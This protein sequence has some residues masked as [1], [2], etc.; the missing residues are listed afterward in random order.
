MDKAMV[1]RG[2]GAIV[3]AIIAALLLGWLLKDKSDQRQEVVDM[4]IPSLMGSNTTDETTPSLLNESKSLISNTVDSVKDTGTAVIASASSVTSSATEKVTDATSA[5]LN[6]ANDAVNGAVQNTSSMKPG[7][8][9]RPS[10]ANEEKEIVDNTR[11][12]I[13]KG[14]ADHQKNNQQMTQNDSSTSA[15]DT[16]V[17]STNSTTA[18]KAI[19][20]AFKPQIVKKKKK[21]KKKAVPQPKKVAKA[22]TATNIPT[23]ASG[24]YSIQLLATSSQ[25]RANKLAKTMKSE[26]YQ[27]FVTETTRN[28]KV[29]FRVRVGG[30]SNRGSAIKAQESMKKRYLKNFFVQNSLVISN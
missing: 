10:L 30:H 16:V 22:T 11:A 2:I 29:L 15:N 8:A 5:A 26:G 1:K 12:S 20:K 7:F 9:I 4:K 24:K 3:L 19:K 17:A 27:V 14:N 18:T 25:S 13:Q 21:V 23:T 6:T 28:D